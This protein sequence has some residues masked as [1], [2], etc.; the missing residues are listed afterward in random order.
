MAPFPRGVTYL[1]PAL[2]S[3]TH[4][5]MSREKFDLIAISAII[6]AIEIP[7]PSTKPFASAEGFSLRDGN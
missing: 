5:H 7:A 4:H 1:G 2:T 3:G 6:V